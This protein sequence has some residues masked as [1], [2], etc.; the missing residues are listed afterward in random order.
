MFESFGEK[1]DTIKAFNDLLR[2][3]G[4]PAVHEGL[5]QTD[6][7]FSVYLCIYETPIEGNRK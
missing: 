5:E 4:R 6:P 1:L 2:A 3:S 7:L